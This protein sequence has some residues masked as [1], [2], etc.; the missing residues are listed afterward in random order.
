MNTLKI[1]KIGSAIID[2]EDSLNDFLVQFAQLSSPKILVHGGGKLAT[3]LAN[4]LGIK[5][6]MLDGRRVT[7]TETLDIITMVYAGKVNTGIVAKLQGANCNAI[8]LT[9]ADANS[10]KANIRLVK[11][12]DYGL[13]GDIKEVNTNF[14]Q[15]ILKQGI[16]PV[17]SAISHNGKG[18]LL[19]TNAD[20]IASELA[21]ALANTF[22]VALYYCFDKP[23]VLADVNDE[24]STI[25][26]ITSDSLETLKAKGIVYKGMLPKLHTSINAVQNNVAK[27]CIGKPQMLFKSNEK[28]TTITA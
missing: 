10:I 14:I 2:N 19:N 22:K 6:T 25:T 18:Q 24:N 20:T 7:N 13:V 8:G 23:G 4:K 1:I 9:G 17:F 28:Y 15:S 11:D 26:N 16:T 27:V 21:I 3:D 12:V 5:V